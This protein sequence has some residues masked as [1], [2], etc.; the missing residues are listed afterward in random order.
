MKGRA[1]VISLLV[2]ILFGCLLVASQVAQGQN[3]PP[4]PAI[5]INTH[6]TPTPRTV[7]EIERDTFLAINA[8]REKAGLST[9][10]NSEE[11]ASVARQHSEEMAT[12]KF[13]DHQ[14]SD[15]SMNPARL[16][17]A[18]ITQWVVTGENLAK[19]HGFLNV[20]QTAIL[21]WLNSEGHKR[22]ILDP[23]FKRTGIGA[24][25]DQDGT[26][27]LTQVFITP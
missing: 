24:A 10:E 7:P 21:E 11:L 26:V 16:Q 9:L 2:R 23:R 12:K 14:S 20:V 6:A 5:E 13:F 27:F 22:L 8:Q 17:R 4:G 1:A 19:V 18:G 3:P 25:I 15:G